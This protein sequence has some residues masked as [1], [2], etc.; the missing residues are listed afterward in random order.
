MMRRREG[1]GRGHCLRRSAGGMVLQQGHNPNVGQIA[2]TNFHRL[3]PAV[4]PRDCHVSRWPVIYSCA[5]HER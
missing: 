3:D 2:R 5:A 4:A 1:R